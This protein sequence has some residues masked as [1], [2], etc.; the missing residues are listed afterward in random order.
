MS[1]LDKFYAIRYLV[2]LRH[3]QRVLSYDLAL[4]NVGLTVVYRCR[5]YPVNLKLPCLTDGRAACTD[6]EG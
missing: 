2:N 4:G 3:E 1:C 6:F 5:R